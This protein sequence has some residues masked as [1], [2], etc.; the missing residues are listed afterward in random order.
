MFHSEMA[1]IT[2]AK[3]CSKHLQKKEPPLFAL[4]KIFQAVNY[5]HLV[6]RNNVLGYYLNDGCAKMSK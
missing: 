1:I 5:M 3:A 2:C 6:I 4:K